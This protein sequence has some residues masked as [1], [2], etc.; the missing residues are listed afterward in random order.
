MKYI[1]TRG[2]SAPVDFRTATLTGLAPD[3]GLYMPEAWPH[4]TPQQM[5]T[6]KQGGYTDCARAMLA[7]YVGD[8]MSGDELGA[9]IKDAYASFDADAAG[10]IIP[11]RALGDPSDQTY[12]ME[13]FH[14]PTL[15][16]KDVAMQFIGCLF[17]RFVDGANPVTVIG[18][19]SGDTGAAAVHAFAGKPGVRIVMLH[20]KGRISAAQRRQM[21]T[22]LDDNVFNISVAGSFDDCQDM[23]KG[24][25]NDAKLAADFALTTVNSINWAR[26]AAQSVYY[27]YWSLKLDQGAGVDFV[28][29][30]GNFGNAF[31]A[32]VA[33]K[34]GFP[35]G[36]V[37]V[38]TNSN[39][40]LVRAFQDGIYAPGRATPTISPAMDISS[41]SNFE[42][43]L[44]ELCGRDGDVLA[45]Y[46]SALKTTGQY[47]LGADMLASLSADYT[48]TRTDEAQTKTMMAKAMKDWGLVIDPHTAVGLW[49]ARGGTKRTPHCPLVCLSTAHPAKFL[50][51]VEGVLKTAQPLP[52]ALEQVMKRPER[53]VD[54]PAA[55][56]QLKSYVRKHL[57]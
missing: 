48:A 31:S 42:R 12:L 49:A 26:I 7:P 29:P 38:A 5:A 25:M 47:Q 35:V 16:F 2:Q 24:M 1:S 33:R 52:A 14:G 55:L 13:L 39:D 8:T 23:V 51:T 36:R 11:V 57:G 43:L 17:D 46:M 37:T 3:G 30:S 22:H 28:V 50:D 56:D 15:A 45:G 41:A 34:M 19:T 44:F 40:V 10:E 54:M 20:P 4:I 6:L 21:T 32:Y 27:G 9:L 18:A 53:A